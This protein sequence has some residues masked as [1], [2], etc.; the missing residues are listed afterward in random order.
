MSGGFDS[1]V[2]AYQ[3]MRRGLMAHFCFF[4]LG[5]RAHELGVMEVAHFIWKKYGSSQRVLFVSVPFEEVVGEILGKVDNSHMGVVLKR[6]M[7]RAAS[8]I[9]DRLHIDA[10]VTGEAISQVSSQTLPNLS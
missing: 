2:A 1:T 6:M 10:L 4:N 3:I 9:A 7:L 8:Q 5:G